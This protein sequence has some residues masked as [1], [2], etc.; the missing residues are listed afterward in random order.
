MSENRVT[1][2]AHTYTHILEDD[3]FLEKRQKGLARFINSVVRH[4]TLK[5]DEVVVTFLT[6]PSVSVIHFLY[7][8]LLFLICHS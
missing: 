4:P 6:E 7:I 2:V 5:C 3:S 8:C 1:H